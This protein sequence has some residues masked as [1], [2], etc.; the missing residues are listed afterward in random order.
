MIVKDW[1]KLKEILERER[2]KGKKIVFTNGCFDILHRGHIEYLNE[3]KAF[4]DILVVA[5]NSDSSVKMIKGSSRPINKEEDRLIMIDAIKPVDYV[6]VF[7]DRTPERIIKFLKPDVH[8]KGGDYS[9]DDLPEARII[10]S[11][12]GKIKI[13]RFRSGYSTTGIIERIKRIKE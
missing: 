10:R 12:G 4:G 5:V 6:T 11:Y 13:I 7:S 2:K 8:V 9:I 1:S 3:A